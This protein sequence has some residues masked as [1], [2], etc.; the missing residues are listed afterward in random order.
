MSDP[1]GYILCVLTPVAIVATLIFWMAA[2][3]VNTTEK[4]AAECTAKG[5]AYIRDGRNDFYCVAIIK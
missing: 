3:T 2:T 5:G 1:I 4:A